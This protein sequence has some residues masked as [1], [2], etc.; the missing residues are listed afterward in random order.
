M[1]RG[2]ANAGLLPAADVVRRA[3]I[4]ASVDRDDRGEV[5]PLDDLLNVSVHEARLVIR[6]AANR[7]P[8]EV[9]DGAGVDA[10]D[11]RT[12]VLVARGRVG[13]AR[14]LVVLG[15]LEEPIVGDLVVVPRRD[16]GRPGAELLQPVVGVVHGVAAAVVVEL[17][18]LPR[19]VHAL[20]GRPAVGAVAPHAVGEVVRRRDAVLVDVVANVDPPVELLEDGAVVVRVEVAL[21][22]MRAREERVVHLCGGAIR[23][24]LGHADHRLLAGGDEGVDEVSACWQVRHVDLDHPVVLRLGHHR[25]LDWRGCAECACTCLVHDQRHRHNIRRRSWRVA[26]PD[27][28]SRSRWA[29]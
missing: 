15:A 17:H 3:S 14:G 26:S 8:L 24:R 9:S 19:R 20:L 1:A 27:D 5:A 29:A 28:D 2:D 10:L 6:A 21:R 23:G 4:A 12:L 11:P 13:R 18:D 7:Q 22:P 25:H 16:H